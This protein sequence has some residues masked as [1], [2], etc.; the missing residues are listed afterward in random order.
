MVSGKYFYGN[1]ASQSGLCGFPMRKNLSAKL[2][3][4]VDRAKLIGFTGFNTISQR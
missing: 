1:I 2:K 4:P 3:N